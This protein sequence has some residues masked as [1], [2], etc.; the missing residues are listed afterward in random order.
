M[1][2]KKE[3]ITYVDDG[4][5]IADMSNVSGGISKYVRSSGGRPSASFREKWGT[6]WGAFR[7]MLV[8]MA[9]VGGCLLVAYLI[10]WLLLKFA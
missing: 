6:F 1:G 3:K 9:C 4:R 5:T 8:P 7:M 2:K 10:L